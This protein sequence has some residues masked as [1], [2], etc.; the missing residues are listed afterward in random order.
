MP[1]QVVT[2]KTHGAD[3]TPGQSLPTIFEVIQH[4][5][6]VGKIKCPVFAN[7]SGQ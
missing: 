5:P 6:S 2:E 4:L 3:P 7:K 1:G